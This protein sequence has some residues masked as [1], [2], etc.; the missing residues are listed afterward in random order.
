MIKA[1]ELRHKNYFMHNGLIVQIS[2]FR[3]YSTD[4]PL[5]RFEMMGG[6]YDIKSLVPIPLTEEILF[7]CGF[8]RFGKSF[9]LN[10]FEYCPISKNLV[11]HGHGGYYTGL[12]LKIQYF[13][14]LQNLYFELTGEELTIK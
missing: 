14:K 7:K 12:I 3:T 11:I 5:V 10:T 6:E 2:G 9:R 4:T 8:T 1:N 13:H